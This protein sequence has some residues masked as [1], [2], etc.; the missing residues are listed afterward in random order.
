[1]V[2]DRTT[3][4]T[5]ASVSPRVGDAIS[6]RAMIADGQTY[7]QDINF[8]AIIAYE[9][10][11]GTIEDLGP[12]APPA[13]LKVAGKVVIISSATE[14]HSING[15]QLE[16]NANVLVVARRVADGLEAET[17]IIRSAAP[18]D[19]PVD[20]VGVL[21]EIRP[22]PPGSRVWEVDRYTVRILPSVDV[23]P[24]GSVPAPGRRVH[25]TGRLE[26]SEVLAETVT[27]LPELAVLE[28]DGIIRSMPTAGLLGEWR[29]EH[30][31][32][33]DQVTFRVESPSV[34]DTRTAPALV[35]MRVHLRLQ[36]A[37]DGKLPVALRVRADW[38]D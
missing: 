12:D 1:L 17:I 4:F 33:R 29:V 19:E 32:E 35:G 5:P 11:E 7:A 8:T 6:V 24:L 22:E 15:Q 38:P 37:G 18:R 16:R 3:R 9:T 36:D 30:G 20:F 2:V 34:I 26:G 14:F 13:W 28:I 31:S 10:L 23:K 25:V 27:L 21:Q